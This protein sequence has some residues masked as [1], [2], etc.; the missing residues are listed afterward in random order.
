MLC[1]S[2]IFRLLHKVNLKSRSVR[3]ISYVIAGRRSICWH[4]TMWDINGM[5]MYTVTLL[6]T[7]MV[8]LRALFRNGE[9]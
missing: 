4:L 3:V 7:Y 9:T 2:N 8:E 5:C 6:K 1:D